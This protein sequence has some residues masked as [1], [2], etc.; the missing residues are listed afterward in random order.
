M[1]VKKLV[2]VALAA[3]LSVSAVV[4]IAASAEELPEISFASDS[5]I[6]KLDIASSGASAE[7]T[8]FLN[9]SNLNAQN[10]TNIYRW[11]KP[12]SSYLTV[13]KSGKTIRFQNKSSGDYYLAE[14]YDSNFDRVKTKFIPKELSVFGGFYD[15]GDCYIIVSGQTN[16]DENDSAEVVRITKYDTSWN[17]LSQAS[18]YGANTVS[19]FEAGSLRFARCNNYLLIR[20][21]HKMY[22]SYDGYNHQ[23]N[24][25]IEYDLSSSRITDSYTKV[26]NTNMGYVSH[27]FNQFITIENNKIVAV[28]HGDAY[29]RSV[30]LV[31]YQTDASTGTFTPDYFSS[32]CKV[33]DAVSIPGNVGANDTGVSVGGFET[34][35]TNYLVAG[36]IVVDSDK[37]SSY[38]APRNVYISSVNKS[39]DAVTMHNITNY[40]ST[41][42]GA[43]NPQFAKLSDNRFIILWS[44]KGNTSKVYYTAIDASGNKTGSTYE[45][46]ASLSDCKP[47]VINGKLVWYVW[48]SNKVDFY[49]INVNN[50][51]QT[52]SKTVN[53]NSPIVNNSYLGSSSITTGNM[54]WMYG[55]A[56]GGSGSFTYSYYYKRTD[57]SGWT[58]VAVNTTSKNYATSIRTAGQYEVK[59][60]AE[61]SDGNSADKIL[62]F[63]ASDPIPELVNNSKVSTT[64]M[65]V[66]D[67]LTVTGAA[68]GGTGGYKY[69]F[70]YKKQD[71]STWSSKGE[72]FGSTT[73]ITLALKSAVNYDIMVKVKDSAG[74]EAS[75]TMT[76]A[77]KPGV[78]NN[79]TVSS[80]SITLG[81]LITVNGAASGGSGSYTYSYYYKKASQSSWST[82]L[83]D[84][85]N[86][87]VTIKPGSAVDY[88]IKVV[89]KDSVGRTAEK[90][91][92]IK[93][94][95]APLVNKSGISSTVIGL[96]ET[97]KLTGAA[98]GG[99]APYKYSYYFKKASTS[100]WTTKAS[101][102]TS[103]SVSIKPG[104]AVAYDMKVVVTDSTGKTSEKTFS[105]SVVDKAAP[106]NN[107]TVASS[108]IILGN[109]ITVKGA[110][111][112]G[113]AP[114]TYS[115][116]FKKASSTSWTAKAK[117][118]TSTSVSIKP[119]SAVTYNIKVVV[120]DSKGKTATKTMNVVV[121]AKEAPVNNSTISATTL[122]LGLS[123]TLKGAASG[124][125]APYKYSYYFKKSS[126]SSWTAKATDTTETSVSIKPG[127]AVS[128][129]FKVVVKDSNNKTSTK[130]FKV[131]VVDKSV[132]TNNSTVSA[133]SIKLGS[134]ITVKGAA[135]GGT[136]PYKYSYYFKRASNTGWTAKAKDTTDTSVTIKPSAA[137]TYNIKVVVTDKNGKSSE[138]EMVVFVKE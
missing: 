1:N 76:V 52:S 74:T 15:A 131:N 106:T 135:T 39:T 22:K 48:N 138:K 136:T 108:S 23:S 9:G 43:D 28:D 98:S 122:N 49:T 35:S 17:R 40:S 50:I 54:I 21:S 30:A 95:P 119:G 42:S 134:S 130:E 102:T 128:Y 120:K 32:R 126:Q 97:V 5:E 96:G 27:S 11:S 55:S 93:V 6:S 86:T 67:T 29:P 53:Y 4:P 132:P 123:V 69:A 12:V 114:Y 10:Y 137:V 109:S 60:V 117:D 87:S 63:T 112:G 38:N 68:S 51:A 37:Y 94:N 115:Y 41:D 46:N 31:K 107:S 92:T 14:Y 110:A 72:E 56:T 18:L 81:K 64:S 78:Q 20:T 26:M 33:I 101:N 82:K 91:F 44:E 25:T 57:Q 80:A 70:Y 124:G 104:S 36:N 75:K 66:G 45:M 65:M 59:I 13:D 111:S 116:Y 7:M 85:T 113:T 24:M 125:T 19:P 3:M 47:V 71:S 58:D 127:C 34:S 100:T 83:A 77:V 90:K 84:T 129:D 88:N 103:P 62:Y 73:S 16:Y 121:A 61:D 99:T 105:L 79:S 2:C 133:A 89:A 8:P 118:T